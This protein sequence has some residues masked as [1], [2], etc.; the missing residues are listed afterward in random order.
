M[1]II[2]NLIK[3]LFLMTFLQSILFSS[4]LDSYVIKNKKIRLF[5][6]LNEAFMRE[7]DNRIYK[8]YLRLASLYKTNGEYYKAVSYYK[9]ALKLYLSLFKK[10]N[11][12]QKLFL[13]K[14]IAFCYKKLGDVFQTFK[15]T[16]HAVKV[17]HILYG[18]NS[19]IA[20]NLE[21]EA[22]KIQ[23]RLIASSI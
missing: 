17:A 10:K 3:F 8:I 12:R 20:K 6:K 13:Y 4:E 21:K 18:K 5:N 23:S 7:D 19:K 15:Y 9:L 11:Y 2:Y 16:Y 22:S 14:N 1:K